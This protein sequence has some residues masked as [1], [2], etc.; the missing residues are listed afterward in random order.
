[1]QETGTTFF[2]EENGNWQLANF[3][4]GGKLDLIYIK[5]SNT[6]TASVEVHVA[7]GPSTD[8]KRILETATFLWKKTTDSG[9]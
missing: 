2:E 3:D 7:S 4:G 6:G 1:I 9:S 8:Q 5:T